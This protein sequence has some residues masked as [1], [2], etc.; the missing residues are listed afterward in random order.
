MYVHPP[1]DPLKDFTPLALVGM[2]PIVMVVNPE[3]PA[4]NLAEL[5]AW[6]KANPTKGGF[7]SSGVGSPHH[8]SG[9]L[10]RMR[11]GAPFF[12]VP[13][14]GGGPALADVLAGHLSM[15]FA[16]AIT[17]LKHIKEGKVR[18]I[19]VT[20]SERYPGL[21]DVP[22]VAETVPGFDMPSWLAFFGPANM[23]APVAKRLS[24]ELL[25]AIHTPEV[26]QKL[27]DSAIQVVADGGPKE[28]AALQ[29]KDYEFKGKL[30]HD[31]GIK[32]Q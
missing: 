14:R 4:K 17:V 22:T 26:K 10:L 12:H 15:V 1:Y 19:A 31:A 13:Y 2:N 30:I 28:L 21:P 5:I 9:E 6:V 11:T 23:P 16:S 32:P 7:G 27:L 24:D 8:L 3:V 29:R 25:K 18:A 20:D